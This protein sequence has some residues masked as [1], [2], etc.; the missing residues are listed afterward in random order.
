METNIVKFMG[1]V[2]IIN[3]DLVIYKDEEKGIMFPLNTVHLLTR[4]DCLELDKQEYTIAKFQKKIEDLDYNIVKIKR[5]TPKN[6]ITKKE[7][8]KFTLVDREVAVR[9]VWN[10]S[11]NAGAFKSFANKEEAIKLANDIN[12]KILKYLIKEDK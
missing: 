2:E 7:E 11:N 12:L 9:Q 3:K 10:V 6:E 1:K 4:V 8:D 5:P